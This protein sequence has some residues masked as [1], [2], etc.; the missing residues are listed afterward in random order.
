MIE[1]KDVPSNYRIDSSDEEAVSSLVAALTPFDPDAF[2]R[3]AIVSD[4]LESDIDTIQLLEEATDTIARIL[5]PD[6]STIMEVKQRA[7][8]LF[9]ASTYKQLNEKLG[10]IEYDGQTYLGVKHVTEDNN[11]EINDTYTI[12]AIEVKLESDSMKCSFVGVAEYEPFPLPELDL[13]N[14]FLLSNDTLYTVH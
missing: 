2:D 11:D 8:P 14:Q 5:S 3:I 4:E 10:D 6:D 9:L 7:N 12:L 13:I 1:T